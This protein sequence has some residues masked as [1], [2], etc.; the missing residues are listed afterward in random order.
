[1]LS[2]HVCELVYACCWMNWSLVLFH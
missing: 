1:M 2:L